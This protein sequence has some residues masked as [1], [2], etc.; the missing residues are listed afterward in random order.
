MIKIVIDNITNSKLLAQHGL[1]ILIDEKKRILFDAGQ[2]EKVLEHNLKLLGEK[3]KF[4]YFVL[5]HGHY[6][7]SDGL[8]YL[9]EN[10][11]IETVILHKDALKKRFY[12][13][14]YIG[15]SEEVKKLLDKVNVIF[16]QDE[17]RIDK[18]NIVLGDIVR[19]FY[20]EP[21]DFK[22][23]KGKDLV[24]DE[25][26][27]I[28]KNRL[29]TGC[30]HSGVINVIEHAKN[31][32]V[33]RLVVGGFHLINAS[34]EYLEEVLRY[35]KVQEFKFIPLHCTGFKAL[36]SLSRLKN[37]VFGCAGMVVK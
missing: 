37:F 17:F 10:E 2:D 35:L 14:R 33:I 5:S 32:E 36:C 9:I 31:F 1:S 25:L 8:K 15:V 34:Q 7:H 11:L 18:D 6:D 4:D 26:I 23:E 30:S 29:I 20:Y 12:N 13:G 27:L 19:K 3:E 28:S 16:I 21:E 24:E 22:D